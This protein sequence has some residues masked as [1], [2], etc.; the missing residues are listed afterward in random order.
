[1]ERLIKYILIICFAGLFFPSLLQAAEKEEKPFNP[2][3]IIFEHLGDEYGWKIFTWEI[4]LPVILRDDQGKWHVFSSS[5]LKNGKEYEGFRIA[6]SGKYATKIVGIEA[7]GTEYRPWDFSIT[8]NVLSLIF[9]AL[10]LCWLVF[11]LLRWYKTPAKR[12]VPPRGIKGM[13]EAVIE[14]LYQDVIVSVLGKYAHRYAPY[15]LTL[16]FFILVANLMG[17]IVVF[18]GGTN[19]MGNISVTLVL[20]FC[21][22]VVVN[23]SG[24]KKYWKE[25]FW[26]EVP[27]WLKFPI[28]MMPVIEIFGVFTKPVALMIRLFANMLGGHLIT[29]VLISLIFIF[30]A[31]GAVAAA[32]TTVIA[33]IFAVFMEL[34]DLL[35]CFIQAY[36]F[37]MLST[38]FI[39]LALPEEESNGTLKTKIEQLN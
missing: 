12:Y 8:K 21:T 11:P 39:S 30:S 36:V 3:D 4:P 5:R 24:R 6:G 15:L 1:M 32:G 28:P 14:M 37:F 26:P 25:I 27:T 9:C 31:M 13:I 38:I 19:L 16:F 29:L 17:L 23:V 7:N 35:I 33:V 20:S 10:A 2:K 34:I 22:F 18:P